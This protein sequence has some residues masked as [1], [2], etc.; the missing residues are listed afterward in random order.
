MAAYAA[1]VDPQAVTNRLSGLRSAATAAAAVVSGSCTGCD[2]AQ[3]SDGVAAPGTGLDGP[4]DADA[5]A[6]GAVCTG[7]AGMFDPIG[8][9]FPTQCQSAVQQVALAELTST[10]ETKHECVGCCML[11]KALPGQEICRAAGGAT[12]S[13]CDETVCDEIRA[14]YTNIT[15]VFVECPAELPAALRPAVVI[16]ALQSEFSL[17]VASMV[18]SSLPQM[19]P[20]VNSCLTNL[21]QE[22]PRPQQMNYSDPTCQAQVARLESGMNSLFAVVSRFRLPDTESN[23]SSFLFNFVVAVAMAFLLYASYRNK[24]YAKATAEMEP[25]QLVAHIAKFK[26]KLDPLEEEGWKLSQSSQTRSTVNLE[27]MYDE[28]G[29]IDLRLLGP[30]T[31]IDLSDWNPYKHKARWVNVK[32]DLSRA[33]TTYLAADGARTLALSLACC[34]RPR[35]STVAE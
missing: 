9:A 14:L 21:T 28:D 8:S 23:F 2:L 15:T 22:F 18:T 12:V 19:P 25:A 26:T 16:G 5:G 10:Y 13:R 11:G 3:C 20:L 34:V 17:E 7:L 32:S 1:A 35:P 24:Q 33:V 6:C 27:K 30:N 31:P 29:N 4:C